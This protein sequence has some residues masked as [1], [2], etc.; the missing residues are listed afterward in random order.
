M[1]K[2]VG[3]LHSSMG[4]NKVT[5]ILMPIGCYPP[6]GPQLPALEFR[7]VS[8][9]V[10]LVFWAE[11]PMLLSCSG[12]CLLSTSHEA[13][14]QKK[15]QGCFYKEWPVR[16]VLW[17]HKNKPSAQD[18]ALPGPVLPSLIGPGPAPLTSILLLPMRRE[19]SSSDLWL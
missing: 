1:N 5:L 19:T 4:Q 17:H 16:T 12:F 8:K 15:M 10:G 7:Q 18:A 3:T 9:S 13:V 14:Q 2:E 6:A 11:S